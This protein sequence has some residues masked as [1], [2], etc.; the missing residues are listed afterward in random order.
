[1]LRIE[2]YPSDR[3][4]P[5]I[6]AVRNWTFMSLKEAKEFVEK[7][8]AELH[9]S[10]LRSPNTENDLRR[11]LLSAGAI[12]THVQAPDLE[13]EAMQGIVEL[14]EKLDSPVKE[15]VATWV[16]DRFVGDK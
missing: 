4:I 9:E 2:T 7:L 14:I 16:Y 6:K 13:I 15:R 10:R 8:P 3:K 5:M 11:D 1:M 12:V